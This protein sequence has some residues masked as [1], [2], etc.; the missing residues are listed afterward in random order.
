M[1]SCSSD[2]VFG[3]AV[4]EVEAAASVGMEIHET[5]HDEGVAVIELR[6]PF[7][8]DD[9]TCAN[10]LYPPVLYAQGTGNNLIFKYK[11][12]FQYHSFSIIHPICEVSTEFVIFVN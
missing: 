1:A 3:S 8:R 11:S 2:D 4:H 12:A 5:G 6:L 9:R 7:V 10:L